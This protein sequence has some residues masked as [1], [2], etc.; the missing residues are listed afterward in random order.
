MLEGMESKEGRGSSIEHVVGKGLTIEQKKEVLGAMQYCFEQNAEGSPAIEKELTAEDKAAIELANKA[1]ND[2]LQ[3]FGK[4]PFNIPT[5]RVRVIRDENWESDRIDSDGVFLTRKQL[6]FVQE[7][8]FRTVLAH[9]V[10]HELIHFKSYGALQFL[11]KGDA[12]QPIEKDLEVYRTGLHLISRNGEKSYLQTLNEAVTEELAKR[13][14]LTHTD[15]PLF[16]REHKITKATRSLS[17]S[18][19]PNS[20]AE[21]FNDNTYV[22]ATDFN[23]TDETAL[24]Q[25]AEFPYVRERKILATLCAKLAEKNPK[26]FANGDAAFDMF[27]KAMLDGNMMPLRIIDR[28]FGEGTLRRIGE[29]DGDAEALEKFVDAL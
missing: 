15:H 14:T 20:V 8:R 13:F 6:I 23:E 9:R 26:K 24:I 22:A 28:I 1:T 16:Q 10:F 3:K 29:L 25:I 11:E 18:E 2:I 19:D 5:E 27:A 17:E 7:S 4:E 21:F 12:R